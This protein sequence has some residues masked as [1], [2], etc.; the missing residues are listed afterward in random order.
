MF[1][2]VNTPLQIIRHTRIQRATVACHDVDKV[3]FHLTK[4]F[5]MNYHSERSEESLRISKAKGIPPRRSLPRVGR[6]VGMTNLTPF[7]NCHSERSEESL[8]FLI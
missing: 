7:S 5:S 2:L 4:I 6:G 1:V 3:V 8:R